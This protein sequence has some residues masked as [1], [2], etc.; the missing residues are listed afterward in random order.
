MDYEPSGSLR[1]G[2]THTAETRAK[3]DLLRILGVTSQVLRWRREQGL[4]LAINTVAGITKMHPWTFA[5]DIER[6][7]LE[8]LHHLI[9]ET[10]LHSP[11]NLDRP[12]GRWPG[13]GDQTHSETRRG[14][15]RVRAIEPLPAVQE[16]LLPRS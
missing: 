14:R 11:S 9:E 8:G 13:G 1:R 12:R 5:A 10:A 2:L 3:S 4:P 7:V 6:S 15:S 16:L